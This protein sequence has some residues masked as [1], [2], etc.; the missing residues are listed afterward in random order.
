M[1]RAFDRANLSC[2]FGGVKVTTQLVDGAFPNYKQLIPGDQ[3]QRVVFEAADFALALRQ[4][5]HVANRGSGVV[6][7]SWEDNA[8]QVSSQSEELGTAEATICCVSQGGL[9]HIA[10][11]FKYL[12][13]YFQGLEGQVMLE[14]T[15]PSSPGL[16]TNREMPQVLVMPMY[17]EWDGRAK[18]RYKV[19]LAQEKRE[20]FQQLIL[21]GHG[22]RHARR[23]RGLKCP[24]ATT[25][26]RL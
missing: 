2:H 11:Y 24:T 17:V 7:L 21:G 14:V 25:P 4:L 23:P 5:Q 10:F 26:N 19:R 1:R 18:V 13:A 8:M 3:E 9:F 16:F 22:A 12:M 15:N 20:Q 6:R